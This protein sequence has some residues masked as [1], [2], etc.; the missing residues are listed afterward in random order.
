M[1]SSDQISVFASSSPGNT[2]KNNDWIFVCI[3]LEI[4]YESE[5]LSFC[6][7]KI[8]FHGG[9]V[10]LILDRT[11][12]K[13]WRLHSGKILI[14]KD[15]GIYVM[16]DAYMYMNAGVCAYMRSLLIN[17]IGSGMIMQLIAFMGW[18]IAK[19]MIMAMFI[20]ESVGQMSVV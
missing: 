14:S 20:N 18:C 11:K 10:S 3:H 2:W 6:R 19:K 17:V 16:V 7:I 1:E 9:H 12:H 5:K 4:M 8:S 15:E 13:F